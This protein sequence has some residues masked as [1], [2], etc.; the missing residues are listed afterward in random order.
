MLRFIDCKLLRSVCV[1][2]YIGKEDDYNKLVE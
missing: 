1:Y 2:E